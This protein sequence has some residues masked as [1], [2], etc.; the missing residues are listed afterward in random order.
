MSNKLDD[1][2]QAYQQPP[3]SKELDEMIAR[4]ER[5][6]RPS[7]MKQSV[8][9]TAAAITLFIGGLNSNASFADAMAKVPVFGQ[10]TEIVTIDWKET[11]TQQSADIKAPQVTLP[12][13]ALEQQL[14]EKYIA[15][16]QALYEKFK[17][18]TNGQEGAFA[19]DSRYDVKTD[20]DDLLSI[21]RIVTETRASA[22]ESVQYDTIDKKQQLVLTLPSLFKNDRYITTISDYLKEE[23]RRQMK[24]DEGKVYFVEGTP[25]VPESEQFK[26][27]SAKQNF[28]ITTD[29]KLVLSFDE[30]S[31]APGYMGIVEFKIPTS[32]L[33]DDLVSSSYIR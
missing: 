28:Y 30:Y 27:I 15:E 24:A 18:E 17:Q 8:L 3:V 32:I 29:H 20:T 16:G 19:V 6:T 7:R 13:K 23:M 2:K 11:K 9:I 4:V 21:G 33:K 25:D 10:L 14:N 26:R 31:I 1:L 12:D 5:R 22:A